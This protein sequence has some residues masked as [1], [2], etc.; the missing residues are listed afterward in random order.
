[1]NGRIPLQ[2][3][4]PD[5]GELRLDRDEVLRY[6]G[7]RPRVTRL[8]E[9]DQDLVDRG[10]GLAREAAAP[11]V[12]LR[13]CAATVEGDEVS[14][15]A[16]GLT[17]RSRSLVRLLR[18]AAG[19]TL[20]AATLG[21]GVEALTT[22]LFEAEEYALATVVDAAGTALVQGLAQWVQGLLAPLAGD[23][24][25]TP[26]YGPGYGDWSL[27]EQPGLL[28]AAGAAQIGLCATPAHCLVPVKSLVGII[29]WTGARAD[30]G[31]CSLCT[32]ADCA[33]RRRDPAGT[34]RNQS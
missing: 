26:L 2:V 7:Y 32:L 17:W 8:A 28:A 33:Y 1:M 23:L 14:V 3:R 15:Q 31:G 29:G 24:H 25:L 6:L 27:E 10:I 13:Y 5:A 9:R 21:P 19:I 30:A 34:G 12:S 20:V 11:A 4:R 22:R 16:L 18:G